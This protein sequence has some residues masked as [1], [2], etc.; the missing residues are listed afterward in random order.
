LGFCEASRGPAEGAAAPFEESS[1][2][3]ACCRCGQAGDPPPA[4]RVPF[5][6]EVKQKV[7]SSV[8][9]SCWKEWEDMEVKVINEYRLNFLDPQH[10]EM[11][12]R[13]CLEFL[14]VG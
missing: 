1:M 2:I 13:A 9:S 14:K 11:L 4:H 6:A 8:C 10:R 3:E 12:Q 7:L 5:P